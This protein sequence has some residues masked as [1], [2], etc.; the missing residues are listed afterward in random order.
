MISNVY[1]LHC[2]ILDKSK[3]PVQQKDIIGGLESKA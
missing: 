1:F 3:T 2:N